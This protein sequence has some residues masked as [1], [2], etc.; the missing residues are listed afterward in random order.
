MLPV[1]VFAYNSTHAIGIEVPP[2]DMNFG[3]TLEEH[4]RLF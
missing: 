4:V 1:V 3:V 2:L